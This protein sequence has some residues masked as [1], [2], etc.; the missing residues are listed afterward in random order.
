MVVFAQ[1]QQLLLISKIMTIIA[2]LNVQVI[3]VKHVVVITI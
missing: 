3:Q 1:T 2:I